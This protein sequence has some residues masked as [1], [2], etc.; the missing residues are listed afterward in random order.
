[1]VLLF[2]FIYFAVL[3]P[4]CVCTKTISFVPVTLTIIH[5]MQGLQTHIAKCLPLLHWFD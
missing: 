1:L 5:S 4:K 3:Y 2:I